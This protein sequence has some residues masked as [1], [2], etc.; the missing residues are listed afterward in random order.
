MKGKA[1][2]RITDRY[3]LRERKAADVVH[4][5]IRG[6]VRLLGKGEL[7]ITPEGGAPLRLRFPKE[8]TASVE[9]KKL[10]DPRLSGAWGPSLQ[11]ITLS[12]SDKAP[13]SGSYTYSLE[14]F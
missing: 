11:R 3:Q 2:L 7:V 1:S 5:L 14:A 8:M 12:G 6:Q 4:F 10:D 13:L 9:E